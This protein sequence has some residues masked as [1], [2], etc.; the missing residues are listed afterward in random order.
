MT[1]IEK[2]H[3]VKALAGR[4]KGRIFVVIEDPQGDFLLLADGKSRKLESP[5]KKKI[6]HT[7][8]IDENDTRVGFKIR[9]GQKV[10]N[11]DIRR[12]LSDYNSGRNLQ[13]TLGGI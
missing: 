4:E 8:F 3:I 5:K 10:T 2:G 12:L 6:K 9:S 1:E 11:A 13:Q 7:V